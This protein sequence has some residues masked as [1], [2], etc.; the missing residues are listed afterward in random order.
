MRIDRLDLTRFGRFTEKT[1]DFPCSETDFHIIYGPNEAGKSTLFAAWLDL[2]YGIPLKT[3]HAFLHE[4]KLMQ[5]GARLSHSGGAQAS[6]SHWSS[7]S[8]T[9]Q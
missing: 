7:S 4:G 5:I 8:P 6:T 3:R 1:L 9:S 2:L